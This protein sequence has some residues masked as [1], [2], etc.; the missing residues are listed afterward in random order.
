MAGKKTTMSKRDYYEILGVS[1]TS[2]IGEIKTSYRKLAMKYHP[3]KNPDDSEAEAKFKEATEAYEVLSDANKRSRYDQYG[4]EGLRAGQDYHSYS[5]AEDI[6]SHINDIFGGSIFDE[7]F[8]G[9][10]RSRGGRRT[11]S[12]G[13]RGSDIRIRLPLTLEEIAKGV[14]KTI[15]IKR[16]KTCDN[17]NGTGANS[18]SGYKTCNACNGTG[19]IRSVSRSMFGQF[20]NVSTCSHC[21]GSGKIISDPCTVCNGDGRVHGEDNISVKIPAGVEEG[22]YLPVSG[23]GNTGRR[24]GESGDLIVVIEEK[25]HPYFIR[26]GNDIIYHLDISIS[27]AVL[28]AKYEVPSLDGIE[29][30]KI[31]SGTRA[32]TLIK[33]HGKGIPNLNSYGGGD[34][35]VVVDIHI[36]KSVSSKEKTILKELSQS[37]NF[38]PKVKKGKEKDFFSKVK[39][40]FS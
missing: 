23:K 38:K 27:D 12:M 32:N 16:Y 36:P 18:T 11:H 5:G 28:G 10:S 20:I 21:G 30:I 37:E 6:F 26:N 14:E 25:E 1:R 33:L 17:C 13:E 15:K 2:E 4:H 19:E 8:G 9:G 3:D 7:F 22:N 24:G 31:E 35:I 29:T 39:G 34:E 40:I